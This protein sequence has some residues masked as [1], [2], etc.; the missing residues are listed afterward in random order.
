MNIAHLVFSF[1]NGGIENMIV[2]I[3]NNTE[4]DIKILLCVINNSY[5]KNLL[6]K[7]NI[8]Q[9]HKVILLDRP[10]KGRRFAYLYKL[11]KELDRF[12]PDIIHMHSNAVFKFCL[13]LKLIHKKWKFVLTIHDTNLYCNLNKAEIFLHK[14]FLDRICA[15]SN[16]VKNEVIKQGVPIKKIVLIYNGI[17]TSKFLCENRHKGLEKKIICVARLVP[18]KK[19][20]DILIRAFAKVI[21]E[22]PNT[23]CLIVGNPP[24]S[25]REYIDQLQ[26]LRDKLNLT[27]KVFFLGNR[28]DVP[29]LLKEC[30][31]F[32]L[33]SRYEGFGISLVEAMMSK[34]PVI[35]SNVDGPKEILQNG[36]FGRLFA[37]GNSEE[38]ARL[39]VSSLKNDNSDMI[40]RAYNYAISTYSIEIMVDKLMNMYA[41]II[42]GGFEA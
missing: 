23:S 28:D 37:P 25:H 19:G 40:E 2:D 10:V 12:D 22:L 1:N 30:D 5:E 35:A 21:N 20:Q 7:I 6:N 15:I 13:P 11:A 3:M 9:T 32:V 33:P 42:N 14:L 29:S 4:A 38:L 17:D 24:D 34:L 16:S 26:D 27:N 39:I 31:L 36:I 8:T 18:P 41:Q